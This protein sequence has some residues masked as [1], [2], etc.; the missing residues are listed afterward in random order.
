MP[1]VSGLPTQVPFDGLELG[2]L[3]GKGGYGRV[4]RG[5]W[6]GQRVAVKVRRLPPWA[7]SSHPAWTAHARCGLSR[8]AD[9]K[10]RALYQHA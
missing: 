6:Y 2:P 1:S 7:P 10:P 9:P 5:I 3:L 8:C 4:F